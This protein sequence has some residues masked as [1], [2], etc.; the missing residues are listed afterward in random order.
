MR[1]IWLAFF[2]PLF[3]MS[4]D[5]KDFQ[6]AMDLLEDTP[7]S[8]ADVAS[9]LKQAL[10]LGVGESVNFLSAKDGFYKSAYKILL[11]AEARKVTD[12]LK[13]IPGFS[14]VE[15][16]LI[17]KINRGAEDAAKQAGPI[18]VSAIKGIS[19]DDAMNIL[20]GDRNAATSYLH[21]RTNT[22]LYSQFKPEIINSL[23]KFNALGYWADAVNTYNKIP[24]ID[25][26]NPDLADYVTSSALT[27]LFDLVEKKED[28]IRTDVTQRSSDLLKKVFAKQDN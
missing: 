21:T 25:K 11:P 16:V 27:G 6:K 14:N 5:P 8:N 4:C 26:V 20:M 19:F 24:F 3:M 18:F 12:K 1:K 13:A 7:L 2:I 15:S 17:E 10:Q 22:Q 9:G 28:G 23:D